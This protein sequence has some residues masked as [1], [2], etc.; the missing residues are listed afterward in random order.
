[1]EAFFEDLLGTQDDI[2]WWQMGIRAV[3][4][5][6]SALLILRS[7]DRRIFGKNAAFDIVLGIILGSVL[8]RAI[9]GNAPFGPAIFASVVLMGLHWILAYFAYH[10]PKFGKLVK[11]REIQLMKGGNL[12]KK[13]MGQTNITEHDLEEACRQNSVETLKDVKDAFIERSGNISIIKAK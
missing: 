9:T 5:F 8:S 7:G 4:V 10:F 11:G 3:I 13:A 12:E 6:L 2:A 1:M